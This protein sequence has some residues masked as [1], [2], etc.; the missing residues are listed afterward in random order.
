MVI[1]WWYGGME[2]HTMVW[3]HTIPQLCG[4]ARA[5]CCVLLDTHI[6]LQTHILFFYNDMYVHA[7]EYIMLR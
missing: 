5:F 3:H 2:I 1:W 7:L 6:I 4:N